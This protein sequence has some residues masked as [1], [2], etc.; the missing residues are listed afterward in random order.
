M[1]TWV[2]EVR[3]ERGD[4]WSAYVT[5]KDKYLACLRAGQQLHGVVDVWGEP[6][7]ITVR[8]V[9]HVEVVR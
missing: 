3:F 2:V 8:P 7:E 6:V 5:A 4:A 1:T 9:R